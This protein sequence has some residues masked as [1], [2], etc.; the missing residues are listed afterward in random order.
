MPCRLIFASDPIVARLAFLVA[1]AAG[2]VLGHRH[3]EPALEPSRVPAGHRI[4]LV[5]SDG[6]GAL[7]QHLHRRHSSRRCRNPFSVSGIW[8]DRRPALFDGDLCSRASARSAAGTSPGPS[9]TASAISSIICSQA[10]LNSCWELLRDE[11]VTHANWS[12]RGSR[13]SLQLGTTCRYSSDRPPPPS[14]HS[15][16]RIRARIDVELAL[17]ASDFPVLGR[18]Y[19]ELAE[20][21]RLHLQN[22][23]VPDPWEAVIFTGRLVCFAM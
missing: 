14:L 9:P 6:L 22:A 3:S 7:F 19:F 10:H 12:G 13:L 16:A 4:S 23:P 8:N 18:S 2:M 21:L 5:P 1:H 11:P 17:A 15:S 20:R